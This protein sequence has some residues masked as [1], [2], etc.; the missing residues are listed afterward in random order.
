MNCITFCSDQESYISYMKAPLPIATLAPLVPINGVREELRALLLPYARALNIAA[1][2]SAQIS[3]AEDSVYVTAGAVDVRTTDGVTTSFVAGVKGRFPLA[4]GHSAE[5]TSAAGATLLIIDRR[6]IDTVL[7]WADLFTTEQ[8]PDAWLVPILQSELLMQLPPDN[9][10][11]L[12][13]NAQAREVAPGASIIRQDDPGDT[14]FLVLAGECSVSRV[15]ESGFELLVAQLEAGQSFGEEALLTAE[16]RNA[17]VEAGADGATVLAVSNADFQ[18]LIH[19][20][21]MHT[22]TVDGF[23]RNEFVLLDVRSADEFNH[24][25]IT[26]AQHTPLSGLRERAAELDGT[27]RYLTYCDSGRRA[28]AAAFL[29]TQRGFDVA[30]VDGHAAALHALQEGH[31]SPDTQAELD[32]ARCEFEAVLK[33]A[34]GLVSE[35]TLEQF[36]PD[37]TDPALRKKLDAAKSALGLA[38]NKS[39]ELEQTVRD[40]HAG[41]DRAAAELRALRN[42]LQAKAKARLEA[43]RNRLHDAYEQLEQQITDLEQQRVMLRED[44]QRAHALIDAEFSDKDAQVVARIKA[45]QESFAYAKDSS[46]QRTDTLRADTQAREHELVEQSERKLADERKRLEAAVAQSVTAIACAEQRL[47]GVEQE[48]LAAKRR[49]AQSI[50]QM[51]A[52]RQSRNDTLVDAVDVD[53]PPTRLEAS[54]QSV[55]D[56]ESLRLAMQDEVETLL[57]DEAHDL[58]EQQAA[59]RV[60]MKELYEERSAA[61][62]HSIQASNT[63]HELIFEVSEQLELQTSISGLAEQVAGDSAYLT[64]RKEQLAS[65]RFQISEERRASTTALDRARAHLQRLKEQSEGEHQ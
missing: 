28:S 12:L 40:E 53:A 15:G 19:T 59:A 26:G 50:V 7:T 54:V 30:V 62:M 32:R 51:Q 33:D 39:S 48:R 20:A 42:R 11:A 44:A 14:Y 56:T 10:Q 60:R 34:A 41:R 49:A 47:A 45:A 58:A 4:H 57:A 36:E 8:Y 43:E 18:T 52:A 64:S 1:G 46:E 37:K 35:S 13:R 17:S 27:G 9:V 6:R 22:I 3:C 61:Q 16:P 29:L 24:D 31:E 2:A 21:V 5:I 63:E 23:N 65:A 38:R 55:V 25:G